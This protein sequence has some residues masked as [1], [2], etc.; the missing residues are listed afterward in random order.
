MILSAV[1]VILVLAALVLGYLFIFNRANPAL[2][3]RTMRVGSATFAIEVAST[4]VEQARGLSFRPGLPDGHGMLFIFSHPAIQNFWMK[5]MNF[6]IDII[7]IGGDKVLG[8]AENAAPQ[9]GVPL[10]KLAVYDSPDGTDKVL[11]VNA[12]TVARDGIRVGDSV[13]VGA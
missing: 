12:G 9:P 2:G 10:W 5:D 6:P 13:Q 8:F 3:D 1:G 4:S 7:W 11:E